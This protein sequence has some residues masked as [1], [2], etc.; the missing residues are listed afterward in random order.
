MG[1]IKTGEWHRLRIVNTNM[2]YLI[3]QINVNETDLDRY[4]VEL[5]E[6]Q[7]YLISTDGIYFSDG[8]RLI[9]DAPYHGAVVIPPGGRADVMLICLKPGLYTVVASNNA[10]DTLFSNAPLPRKR[11]QILRFFVQG[12]DTFDSFNVSDISAIPKNCTEWNTTALPCSFIPYEYS[13]YL[14]DTQDETYPELTS[15]CTTG[16][17]SGDKM[18]QCNIV[19]QKQIPGNAH[20]V[21]VSVNHIKFEGDIPLLN[22]E[23]D[24]VHEWLVTS[25][26]HQ[27]HQHIWPFQMQ[28]SVV[29]G[30]LAQ[31]VGI[32]IY[33]VF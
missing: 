4:R 20:G 10:R 18:T 1:R 8:P 28:N 3:W 24:Y 2:A 32:A 11:H 6:C 14:V 25:N 26:F 12:N 7:A 22:I 16:R 21:Q 9:Y 27:F 23:V 13:P 17:P 15:F 31:Q 5:D 30:W 29:D 33:C 19:L